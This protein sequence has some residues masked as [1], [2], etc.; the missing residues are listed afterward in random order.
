MPIER[1]KRQSKE[2]Q[3]ESLR[4]RRETHGERE[5]ER[6]RQTERERER[7]EIKAGLNFEDFFLIYHSTR[8]RQS[9]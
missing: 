9:L 4:E 1:E 3:G 2:R 6:E 8:P 5:R 7:P